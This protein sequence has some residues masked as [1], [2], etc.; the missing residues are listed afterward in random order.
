MFNK[1]LLVLLLSLPLFAAQQ[2][3]EI[4]YVTPTDD[5]PAPA[6]LIPMSDGEVLEGF[7]W[8]NNDSATIFPEVKLASVDSSGAPDF[9]SLLIVADDVT[10]HK[11]KWS[12]CVFEESITSNA[13]DLFLI[14]SFP[15]GQNEVV[16]GHGAAIG[17]SE[18]DANFASFISPDCVEWSPVHYQTQ[19]MIE[20]VYGNS[21]ASGNSIAFNAPVIPV[22]ITELLPT[23]PN[24]FN[25]LTTISF[26]LS[27]NQHAEVALYDIKG[28]LVKQLCREQL[29]AGRHEF[30]W[31]GVN[32]S[33]S[34]VASGVYL[35]RMQTADYT[36]SHSIMLVK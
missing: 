2:L 5:S 28:R 7:R 35:V 27:S 19:V 4:L 8:F 23:A 6:V 29:D 25:P 10:G 18:D 21:Q 1:A 17:Y 16:E 32:S 20:P 15:V 30:V 14:I 9:E 24:P 22:F 3:P 11:L 26:T 34:K 31:D 36:K 12:D 13:G 33:G